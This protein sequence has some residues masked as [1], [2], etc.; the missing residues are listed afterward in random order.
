[1]ELLTLLVADYANVAEGNKLNVIGVFNEIAASA[2]PALHP[3]MVIVARFS[4][5]PAEANA[6]RKVNIKVMDDDGKLTLID[7]PRDVRVDQPTPGRRKEVNV[8]LRL[9]GVVFPHEGTYQV[10]VLVDGDEKG[11]APLYVVQA[12]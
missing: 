2:F 12:Q 4:A 9:Q 6:A 5:S 11:H 1:M 8:I 7:F 10:S 3:S